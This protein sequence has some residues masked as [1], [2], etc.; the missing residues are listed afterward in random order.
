MKKESYELISSDDR[1]IYW[2]ISDG[3]KQILKR[4]NF[5]PIGINLYNLALGDYDEKSGKFDYEIKS[6]NGDYEKVFSTVAKIISDF[7]SCYPY[8]AVIIKGNIEYKTR[9]YLIAINKF[10]DEL[11][12]IFDI[13]GVIQN[14]LNNDTVEVKYING[15]KYDAIIVRNKRTNLKIN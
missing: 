12:S 2:F 4:V 14:P 10:Y 1:F 5:D 3:R 13:F 9:A 8:Y 11:E 15:A 6:A 7:L